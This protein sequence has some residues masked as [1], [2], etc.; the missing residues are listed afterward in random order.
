[1]N[2]AK[3]YVH[4]LRASDNVSPGLICAARHGVPRALPEVTARSARTFPDL[5]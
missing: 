4:E 3:G 5:K 1:M 2:R